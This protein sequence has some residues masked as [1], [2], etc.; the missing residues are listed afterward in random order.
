MKR[1]VRMGRPPLPEGEA[2]GVVFTV[3]LSEAER[4]T[5][6]A[7]AQRDGQPATKWARAV[8]LSAADGTHR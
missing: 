3:R 2:R 5:I 6:V 7:A 4:A 1:K 8:L